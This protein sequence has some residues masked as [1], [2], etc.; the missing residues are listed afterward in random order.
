VATVSAIYGLCDPEQYMQML[1]HLKVGEELGLKKAQTKLVE[2]QYSRNDMDF[3]RG[4]FRVRGEVLDIFP[5]DSEKDAIRVE[6]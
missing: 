3:S 1:L 2:M 6:F 5:A 4:R